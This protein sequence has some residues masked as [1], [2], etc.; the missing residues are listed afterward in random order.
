MG[1]VGRRCSAHVGMFLPD[2]LGYCWFYETPQLVGCGV[3]SL[4]LCNN[5]QR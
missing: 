1:P 2:P 4:F 5:H 3:F